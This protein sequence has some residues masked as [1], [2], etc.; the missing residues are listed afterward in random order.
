MEMKINVI[1]ILIH[2]VVSKQ[3]ARNIVE[4]TGMSG[5][6]PRPLLTIKTEWINSNNEFNYGDESENNQTILSIAGNLGNYES[7]LLEALTKEFKVK[8][9]IK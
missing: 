6:I 2:S 1:Q 3:I 7:R 9:E 4:E 8:V 5:Q